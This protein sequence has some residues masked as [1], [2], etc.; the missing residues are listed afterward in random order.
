MTTLTFSI[1]NDLWLSANDRRHWADNAKRTREL[2]ML[3][4]AGVVRAF[5][6]GLGT[7]HVAAFIGYPRNSKADPSN[8]FPTV[9]ALIDGLVDA[10]VWPDDDSTHVIGPTYL[11]GNKCDPNTH[12][13]RL[14]LTPQEIPW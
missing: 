5:P 13:V 2:R 8:A 3:G 1:P 12:T 10:G 9:K 6:R 14:V 7:T 11:R 4:R